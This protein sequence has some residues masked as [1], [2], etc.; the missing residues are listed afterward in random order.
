MA[1]T[2]ARSRT[3]LATELQHFAHHAGRKSI[4]PEDVLLC[5]RR[6]SSTVLRYAQSWQAVCRN[7]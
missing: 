7:A 4:K 5:A 6:H 2:H 3:V 1:L